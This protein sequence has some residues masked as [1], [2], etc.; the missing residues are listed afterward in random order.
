MTR[1][2]TPDAFA[3]PAGAPIAIS[4]ALNLLVNECG[5]SQE[6]LAAQL[7]VSA[8]VLAAMLTADGT[9]WFQPGLI[10]GL[11]GI[12]RQH[13]VLQDDG[14]GEQSDARPEEGGKAEGADPF[15]DS[16]E[17][18]A[19]EET[20]TKA[21]L[22]AWADSVLDLGGTELEL[23]LEAAVK[24]FGMNR[25][26]LLRIV[27]A[28]RADRERE[29]RQRRQDA[30]NEEDVRYYGPDF[31]VSNRGVFAR[32]RDDDG[33]DYWEQISSTRIDLVA[34][35][36][37]A[38]Q[39]NWGTSV[40][41]RNRDGGTKS[42]AIPH[43]LTAADKSGEIAAMLA[44]LGV[45]VIPGKK[46]RQLLLHFLTTNVKERTTA[47]SQ[48]GWYRSGEPWIFVLPDETIVPAGFAG[49]CAVLQTASLHV[50]HG[51]DVSGSV[52]QW[53]AEVA[54]PLSGNSNVH[55]CVGVALAGPLLKWANEPPGLFHLWG[56]SKIA[57]S[58]AG[59]IGQSV[60]GRP[61]VPGE[62]DAFGASWT[63][64]AVGLERYAVL[65]SDVG[66]YFDEIGEGTPKIIRPA[67]YVLANGSTK[68]R[69]N[70][71]ITLRPMESFRILGISTGEPTME[72]FLSSGGD[73]VPAG[74]TV[75]LVDVP[76][77]VQTDSAF[78]TCPVGSIETLGKHFYPLTLRLHGAVG[79]AWLRYLVDLGSDEIQSALGK[80][81]DHWLALPVVAAV[82]AKA[83]GQVRSILNRFALVAAAL[84]MAV[85]AK[86]L[87]WS[88]EDTDLG[89]AAC[90]ARW[91]ATRKGRL[92]LAGEM[93]S[94]VEQV[95]AVLT[96]NLH[97][98]F[99]HL[100]LAEE[101]GR[102]TYATLADGTKRDT[103]GYVKEGRILIEPT[104]W[105][106]VLCAGYDAEKTARHLRD[107][108]LLLADIAG[109]KLQRQEKVLRGESVAKARFYVLDMKILND[110][111]GT[112]L[113]EVTS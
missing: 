52:D 102:L 48:I 25:A 76:A 97:G 109:G 35:T 84:R 61:K 31:K 75:R 96:A 95:R 88:V 3:D 13:G 29:H 7:G 20:K 85:D 19:A 56:T 50:Q 68:L 34:L 11:V 80:H 70:A 98:R 105:R 44:S 60:W 101:D 79:R 22:V 14:A 24:R 113:A 108:G 39:E 27:K 12:L 47:V 37:D 107:E 73:K 58:L 23:V 72:A 59:A 49:A 112:G 100:C 83:T 66:G 77:E 51:L 5:V 69:G 54:A 103:L 104:A 86:L 71:D 92:D 106:Q 65:R 67:V 78:E 21:E 82:R 42:L 111:A 32:E 40:V 33:A 91:A 1:M 30:A 87:P 28:R 41:V 43:S 45:G 62:A 15:A 57:K 55:L 18:V 38:R 6:Q 74:L 99:V 26:S 8:T 94:A 46:A 2:F 89:V 16:A 36:R 9:N 81:R 17:D 53:I 64:T 110:A 90:M 4:A 93:L 63:A 10:D